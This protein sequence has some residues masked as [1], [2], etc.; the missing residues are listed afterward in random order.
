MRRTA[1]NIFK[2]PYTIRRYGQQTIT[3]GYASAPYTDFRTQLNVQP[4]SAKEVM[5]LPEGERAAKRLKSFGKVKLAHSE[6]SGE[7]PG[8][9]IF[10]NGEWFECVSADMW[11]HTLLSHWRSEFIL[12]P[13]NEQ[14]EAP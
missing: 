13:A 12:L 1:I 14:E 9:R 8:D 5:A 7:T 10:Y 4:L 3:G 2:K 11:D 6:D